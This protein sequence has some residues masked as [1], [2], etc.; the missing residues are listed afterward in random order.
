MT[1]AHTLL[2]LALVTVFNTKQQ[3]PLMSQRQAGG[4]G[5]SLT[6]LTLHS[7]CTRHLKYLALTCSGGRFQIQLG[8]SLTPCQWHCDLI[9][10]EP[11]DWWALDLDRPLSDVE[12]HGC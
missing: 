1:C 5:P 3:N 12:S 9:D 6:R 2:L 8:L 11:L 4:L 10:H 7:V